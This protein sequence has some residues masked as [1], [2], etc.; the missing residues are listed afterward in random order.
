MSS[1]TAHQEGANPRLEAFRELFDA[2]SDV[3][4][5]DDRGRT[6]LHVLAVDRFSDKA[7]YK[8]EAA[9]LLLARGADVSGEDA[10]GRTAAE[11]LLEGDT[12]FGKLLRSRV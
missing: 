7:G 12:E 8:V 2:G 6:A 11:S 4:A 10:T 3:N 9:R 5:R 1:H